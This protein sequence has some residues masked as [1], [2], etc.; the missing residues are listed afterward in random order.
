MNTA[1]SRSA[2]SHV[3]L[4]V[5]DL[6]QA[7]A[8]FRAAGF[9]VTYATAEVRAQ[10]AHIWFSHGP[11]IELLTTPRHAWLF[12]WPIDC[13][14]G[15]GAG[16]RML[17]WA[18]HGEGFCDLALLCDDQHLAPRLKGLAACGVAMGRM[19]KW[20]RTCVDGSQTRFR[21]VY[22]R[23]A[24]LPFLVTPYTPSQHPARLIHPNGA[25]GLAAIHLGVSPADRTALNLLAGDDPMLHLQPA[26]FTGVQA[27]QIAGLAQPL[28]LHGAQ[29]LN[30]PTA[31]GDSHA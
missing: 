20:Q 8:N 28:T 9:E 14:A 17:R 23:H 16:R 11:I 19:V 5:R 2:C 3:L 15:R 10:H 1:Q 31:E 4:W 24:R 26:E 12:K 30:C 25:T 29:L 6:H 7:V 21:F 13:L 22:P 18:A 27:V